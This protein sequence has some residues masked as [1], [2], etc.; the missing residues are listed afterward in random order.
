MEERRS[1]IESIN[2]QDLGYPVRE[3][4][5]KHS[6]KYDAEFSTIGVPEEVD[7]EITMNGLPRFNTVPEGSNYVGSP[8]MTVFGV[9]D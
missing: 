7:T 6:S 4:K 2:P 1:R 9:E 5:L 3:S 8:E